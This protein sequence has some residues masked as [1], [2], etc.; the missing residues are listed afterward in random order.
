MTPHIR[1]HTNNCSRV[2]FSPKGAGRT[3]LPSSV[4]N[5]TDCGTASAGVW[6]RPCPNAAS[7]QGRILVCFT[8]GWGFCPVSCIVRELPRPWPDLCWVSP[9]DMLYNIVHHTRPPPCTM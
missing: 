5:G 2:A 1:A 4:C 3:L 9:A 7:E 8:R 6:A